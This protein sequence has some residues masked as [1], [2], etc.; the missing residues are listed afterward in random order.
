MTCLRKLC[1]EYKVRLSAISLP[2]IVMPQT[3]ILYKPEQFFLLKTFIHL[4][5]F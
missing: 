4:A 1:A 5:Q 2:L 3:K